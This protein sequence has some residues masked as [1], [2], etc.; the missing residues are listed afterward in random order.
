MTRRRVSSLQ[1]RSKPSSDN[2]RSRSFGDSTDIVDFS[3]GRNSYVKGISAQLEKLGMTD[4]D[5]DS[6]SSNNSSTSSIVPPDHF[7]EIVLATKEN[8]RNVGWIISDGDES[9]DEEVNIPFYA[10]VTEGGNFTDADWKDQPVVRQARVT[11]KDDNEIAWMERHMEMT[12]GFILIG[13]NPGLMILGE[14]THDRQDLSE[15]ERNFPDINRLKGYLF[16]PGCGI[17]IKK[18]TWHDFP[19][20]V[21]PDVN[22]FILNTREVVD[23]LM[24]MEAPAPMDFG[25]CYKIKNADTFRT[26]TLRYPDPRPIAKAMGLLPNDTKSVGTVSKEKYGREMTRVEVSPKWADNATRNVWVVPIVNVENF[27]EDE[28]GPSVQPHLNQTQPEIANSGWRDY[29][30]K[31]GLGRLGN[32][33]KHH[34]IACTA[35]VSSDLAQDN[36]V[37]SQL[38]KLKQECEWEIGAHGAN[39]SNGGHAGLTE[40]EEQRAISNC[41][42]PL[43]TVFGHNKRM[44]WLTPGFSVTGSTPKL[45]LESGVQ[46]LLDFVDDDVPYMLRADGKDLSGQSLVCLP[47]SLE[48]NDFT[49]ILT[50]HLSPR[51]YACALESHI[52][53][54]ARESCDSGCPTVVCLGLHTFVAGTPAVVHELDKMLAR[55]KHNDSITWATA[56]QVSC[57]IRGEAD[58]LK[59]M[60]TNPTFTQPSSAVAFEANQAIENVMNPIEQTHFITIDA[61]PS[62]IQVNC[63]GLGLLLVDMQNDFMSPDGFGEQLGN[64]CTKLEHVVGPTRA[65]LQSARS[66]DLTIIHT[67][68]NHRSNLAD[69]THLKASSCSSIGV[70]NGKGR[71]LVRGE[72]GSEFVSGLEPLEHETVI[73]KSGKSAFYQTDLELVLRNANVHTL[74]VC[75]VTTEICVHSTVRDA[76]DRGIKCIVLKD[77]TASYFDSFHQV[78]IEM[79]SAQGGIFGSVS[80]SKTVIDALNR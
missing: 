15:N 41:I 54:L 49:L 26:C 80:E 27:S 66:A 75:G 34:S 36:L 50:R 55:L 13:K 1:I 45:L 38:H 63:N 68:E 71:S 48:C 47:Y 59:K 73:D 4:L 17:I 67:R 74:I 69:L 51:E 52:L 70:S 5:G 25:D 35:V 43:E 37:M 79:I 22:I 61:I 31:Q 21:G 72:W 32:L 77:C 76:T 44:T 39:N 7:V 33:F 9:I 14:P 11:W 23:A 58:E 56:E 30:N 3:G 2:G 62:P 24:S 10:H 29:G 12:Q 42:K 16:P 78:G 57:L 18:G 19:V 40:A 65:V 20:S 6:M 64:D 53:Q 60:P 28:F 46:T 8:T